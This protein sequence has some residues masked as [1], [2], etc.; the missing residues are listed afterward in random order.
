VKQFAG[1]IEQK[2]IN[3]SGNTTF[4]A[5]EQGNY[6][7]FRECIS[8]PVMR[9]LAVKPAKLPRKR[10]VARARKRAGSG[11]ASLETENGEQQQH[12]KKNKN[13]E[14][15]ESGPVPE[16]TRN[17]AE[18]LGD[19]IDVSVGV[20]SRPGFGNNASLFALFPILDQTH[21]KTGAF[22]WHE[23]FYSIWRSSSSHRS[24]LTCARSRIAPSK[25]TLRCTTVTLSHWT[26]A[27]RMLFL[28]SSQPLR[29]NRSW[30]TA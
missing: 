7:T 12:Q 29:T 27:P 3:M 13:Q 21:A 9:R 19:F 2:R 18:E 23:S 25:R 6:E 22:F 1:K 15:D 8:E 11:M 14:E 4:T 17:D 20:V 30:H 26:A 5:E 24:P 10:R 16:E 28:P